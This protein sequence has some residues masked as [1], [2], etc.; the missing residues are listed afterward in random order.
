MA[1]KG[2]FQGHEWISGEA[3]T[4]SILKHRS[5]CPGCAVACIRNVEILDGLFSPVDP[6][7]GGCET[8]TAFGSLC[9]NDDLRS[10]AKASEICNRY[11]VDTI[12]AGNIIAW[13]MECYERGVL[14]DGDLDGILL[15]WGNAQGIM[16]LLLKTCRREGIGD[17]L[18]EGVAHAA[19]EIG[20]GLER[21]AIH[22]K[23]LEVTMH[24]PRGKKGVGL[25][26][27]T[28]PRGAAH[29]EGSHDTAFGGGEYPLLGCLEP[30]DR[31][32]IEGKAKLMHVGSALRA[33]VGGT[34]MCVFVAEPFVGPMDTEMMVRALSPTTGWDI[35]LG[36]LLIIG[37]R[38][39]NLAR[40]VNVREGVS[41]R[42]DV[43]PV[44]FAEPFEEGPN[45]EAGHYQG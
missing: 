42:E 26:Y 29:T 28:G 32:G 12:S 11:G 3:I 21:F 15:S 36:E 18:A 35:S 39:E 44:H 16:D 34:G 38:M 9:G 2:V 31:F 22:V 19:Q 41:R 7:Y 17:L 8:V 1:P 6:Y 43:L 37:E 40:P 13:A 24:E 30:V 5:A 45:R 23:G 33:V 4:Q 20:G 14:T 10:I 27:A 25:L